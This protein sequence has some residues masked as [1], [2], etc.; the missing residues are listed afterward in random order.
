MALL[1]V[2]IDRMHPELAKRELEKITAAGLDDIRFAWAGSSEPGQGHYY[3]IHGPT[4]LVEF[5]NT[6]N[7]A[8]H[9]HSVWRDFDG[10]FGADVLAEHYAVAHV[11]D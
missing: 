7:N 1:R 10:D 5:D 11:N 3:R 8:N 6:Q 2:Y 9:V 4:F